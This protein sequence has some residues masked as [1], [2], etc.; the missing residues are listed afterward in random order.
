MFFSERD[1]WGRCF[2]SET[3]LIFE[4]T[5]ATTQSNPAALSSARSQEA[6]ESAVPKGWRH[7]VDQTVRPLH[8]LFVARPP[9]QPPP[10]VSFPVATVSWSSHRPPPAALSTRPSADRSGRNRRGSRR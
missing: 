1:P 4:P 3:P 5:L 7:G 8:L 9:P 10:A 6:M 2:P